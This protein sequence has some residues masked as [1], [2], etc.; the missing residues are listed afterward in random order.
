MRMHGQPVTLPKAERT[1]LAHTAWKDA[2]GIIS[3]RKIAKRHG[4][5]KSTLYDRIN[6]G[7]SA[8]QY[9]ERR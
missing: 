9:N 1:D 8:Q 5:P 2:D 7:G 6:G 4:I 3:G